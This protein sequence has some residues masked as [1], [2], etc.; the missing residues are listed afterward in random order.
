MKMGLAALALVIL[1]FASTIGC[2]GAEVTDQSDIAGDE[3]DLK[4]NVLGDV[5]AVTVQGTT[6][7]ASKK[8]SSIL[9]LSGLASGSARPHEGMYRCMP[10]FKLEFLDKAGKA[11]AS[12]G[13]LC[14]GGAPSSDAK[15]YVTVPGGK[16]YLISGD[17]AAIDAIAKQPLVVGDFLWGVTKVAFGKPG[18]P[19]DVIANDPA[20]VARAVKAINPTQ[21]PDPRV[22]M[23]RCMPNHILTF[24][25]GTHKLAYTS[26]LCG[27]GGGTDVLA[28]FSVEGNDDVHGGVHV[29]ATTILQIEEKL[30]GAQP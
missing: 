29:N 3:D 14:G 9:R 18:R 1:A 16:S 19:E 2:A 12:G 7:G 22:S 8:V 24:S 10:Q 4:S 26:F 21:E 13:F 17:A 11:L 5:A 20:D 15:G 23:P 30:R 28:S 27:S 6:V 25:R